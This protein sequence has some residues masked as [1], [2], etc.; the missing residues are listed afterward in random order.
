[1]QIGETKNSAELGRSA[2][3][4]VWGIRRYVFHYIYFNF[5][6]QAQKKSALFGF[7]GEQ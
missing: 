2:S 1:M 3:L 7:K 6:M 5:L 4:C